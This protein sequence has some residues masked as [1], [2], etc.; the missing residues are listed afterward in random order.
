MLDRLESA[1]KENIANK[2]YLDD[3]FHSM[4]N[5]L[6]VINPDKT[7]KTVNHALLKL[8]AYREEELLGKPIDL[9]FPNHPDYLCSE[10]YI[11]TTSQS[12]ILHGEEY[13]LLSKQGEQKAVMLSCS[14]I[15]DMFKKS[16]GVV[17]VAQ[18]YFTDQTDG[19]RS[20]KTGR[21]TQAIS[22][23]GSDRNP[24]RWDS[25]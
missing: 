6:V 9:I 21:A 10:N 20:Q 12:H 4:L 22:E 11:E 5:S 14:I 15:R 2:T 19:G 23:N 18:G 13:T 24:G 3:I 17:C 25:P 7:I 8:L 1:Q 16:R